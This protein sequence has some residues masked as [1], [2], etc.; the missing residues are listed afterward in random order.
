[1]FVSRVMPI[2]RERHIFMNGVRFL[3]AHH[4]KLLSA[5]QLTMVEAL[6]LIAESE[7]FSTFRNDYVSGSGDTADLVALSDLVLTEMKKNLVHKRM[8]RPLLDLTM[9]MKRKFGSHK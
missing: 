9:Q 4:D 3:N 1:M 2:L 6:S 5:S 7:D 8:M